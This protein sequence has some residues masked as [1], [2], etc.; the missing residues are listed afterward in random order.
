M[1]TWDNYFSYSFYGIRALCYTDKGGPSFDKIGG[2]KE[3][4]E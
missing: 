3:H 2:G 1:F 4:S